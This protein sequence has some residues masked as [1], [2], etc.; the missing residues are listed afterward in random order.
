M[1]SPE[2]HR[3]PPCADARDALVRR[4]LLRVGPARPLGPDLQDQLD[5]SDGQLALTV[6]IPV[7][8][9]SLM[10]IPLG[11]LTDRYGGR[12]MFTGLMAF[13]PL[14]LVGLALFNDSWTAVLVFGFLLGF[15]GASF[16]IGVPFV[17]TWYPAGR[18]G[19]ALGIYGIGMGG[20]VVG[21]LAAPR[22]AK[23]TSLDV[24]FWIAAGLV[25]LM[26][27][28]FW[29]LA[30]DAPGAA[31]GQDG[32]DVRRA[33][34]L[35]GQ[36]QQPRVGAH[37]LLLHGLRRLRG[38]VPLPAEAASRCPPP[39]Q[40]GR[41]LPR[42]RVRAARGRRPAH[43]RLGLGQDGCA[44]R[45]DRLVRRDVLAGARPGGHVHRTW[46]RSPSPV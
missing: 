23:A 4:L 32:L 17:N 39:E 18:Q 43:R 22:I 24:P 9:G 35:Q 45:A 13:T 46:C 42:R 8:L 37:A 16:A 5:L 11:V 36:G 7:L 33:V 6:A 14:P 29:L 12:R 19:F 31:R 10:R 41:R 21:A 34:R 30:E 27:L 2:Q 26:A 20:T 1:S 3:Q 38:D 40:A 44:Q 28:A 15:A 25:A